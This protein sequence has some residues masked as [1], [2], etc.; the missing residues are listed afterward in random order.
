MALEY[1][2]DDQ[3]IVTVTMNM[4]GRSSNIINHDFSMDLLKTVKR[5]EQEPLLTGVILTSAKKTFIDGVDIEMLYGQTDSK[6]C[7]ELIESNKA[8]MRRLETLDKPVVA[9]MNGTALGGGMELALCCHHRIVIDDPKIKLGFPEVNLGILPG[10]GGL[11]RLP[12]IIGIE[13]ALPL[14]LE[15]KQSSPL[16]ALGSGLIDELAISSDEMIYKAREWIFLNQEYVPPWDQKG[17]EIPLGNA[18]NPKIAQ[19]LA[20]LT[21]NLQKK[22]M[23]NYPAPEAILRAVKETSIV[24]FETASRIES[25]FF[26]Q[27][28]TGQVSKNMMNTFWFQLNEINAGASRPAKVEPTTTSK[29]GVLGA[30]LMGHGITYVTALAGMEVVMIDSSQEHVDKGLARIESNLE[31]GLINGLFNSDKVDRTLERITATD[32]YSILNGCDLIIEAVFEE[33]ELKGKVTTQA[34]NFMDPSGVFASNTSTIPITSLAERSLRPENYIGI[35]FFSPVHKMKLVEIIKATETSPATLAKAFDYV[36]KIRK[37]PIVVND[38]RGFYTSRVFERYTDEGMALLVEGNH[39][40][41]IEHAGKQAGYPVGPLAVIDEINIGLV[42]NIRDQT[43]RDLESEGKEFSTGPWDQ[44]ID[45]MTKEAKRTGRA[46]GGGFYEYPDDREKYL[47]P[48]LEKHFPTTEK[49]VPQKEMIDRFC[50]SQV[51][52]TIRC[53][54]EGILTSVAEANIGSIFG[55]GFP[56]FKGGTLQ[57]VNDYGISAFRDRAKDLADKYGERFAPPELLLEMVSKG[58]TF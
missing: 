9:A 39:P 28:T 33:R 17:Y 52:E 38:G 20:I 25:N 11:T 22:T 26:A 16:E 53:Y 49:P 45:F 55:W 7:L 47:W 46:S 30:G 18:Q 51:M 5:L 1:Q 8:T 35:H 10:G 57:F 34:E 43:W 56:P 54:E 4:A 37:I 50:F 44:V 6:T 58:K 31:N 2:K 13:A 42:A 48:E 32:D 14:L 24:E 15:G 36:L 3:N 21:S 19:S 23:G 41:A 12:R 29:V 27:L 40:Q